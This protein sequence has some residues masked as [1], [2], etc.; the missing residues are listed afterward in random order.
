MQP[1]GGA[2]VG[3]VEGFIMAAGDKIDKREQGLYEFISNYAG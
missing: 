2:R 1:R 3:Q